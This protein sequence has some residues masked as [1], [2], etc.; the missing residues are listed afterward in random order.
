[1]AAAPVPAKSTRPKFV[2]PFLAKLG[3][4]PG[5]WSYTSKF[6]VRLMARPGW[7]LKVRIWACLMIQSFGYEGD[8][9]VIMRKAD[10]PGGLPK[11][12][13]LKPHNII[14]MLNRATVE[15]YKESKLP[16]SEEQLAAATVSRQHMRRALAE[17]ETQDG[18]IVRV[19][20]NV[21]VHSLHGLS[22]DEAINRNAVTPLAG[23]SAKNA[24]RVQQ[25]VCVYLLA[26]PKPAKSFESEY[27]AK[28]HLHNSDKSNGISSPLAQLI[29]PF[30]SR[31]DRSMAP[32]V[33]QRPE[34]A[35]WLDAGRQ[36]I[37]KAVQE[38]KAS[39][40]TGRKPGETGSCLT[41]SSERSPPTPGIAP[42]QFMRLPPPRQR[43]PTRVR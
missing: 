32:A 25:K 5:E 27:V 2:P 17:M 43:I 13:P 8:L 37:E 40:I 31:G 3:I 10:R 39:S 33:L 26:R 1:M 11:V 9:A 22:I 38:V 4:A 28:N 23:L 18:A 6:T 24:A 34:V 29:L 30:L 36:L 14:Q 15:A 42:H 21:P 41:P 35:A 19:R 20:A 7:P 16:L 12:E